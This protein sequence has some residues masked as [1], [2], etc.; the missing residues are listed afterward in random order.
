MAQKGAE[1]KPIQGT[2]LLTQAYSTIPQSSVLP[3]TQ[4][5]R[6]SSSLRA[7]T[8]S[9]RSSW[10]SRL[11][12]ARFERGAEI[13]RRLRV[14]IAKAR[15]KWEKATEDLGLEGGDFKPSEEAK[16]RIEWAMNP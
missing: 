13:Q 2:S 11:P 8:P 10:K 1:I 12:P 14:A 9:R 15:P 4:R 16:Q 6:S 5:R 3:P 7:G